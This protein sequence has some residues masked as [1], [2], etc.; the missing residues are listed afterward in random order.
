MWGSV[1]AGLGQETQKDPRFE[2]HILPIFQS[3]CLLCHGEKIQQNGLDLRTRESVLRGG[4]TGPAIVPGSVAESLLF[5]KVS[6]GEMPTGGE[7]LSAQK[8]EVIRRWIDAGGLKEGETLETARKQPKANQVTER[9]VMVTILH[10]KCLVCH[11]KRKQEGELNLRTRAG[12]LKGG[13]SGPAMVLGKPEESL[14]IKRIAAGDHPSQVLQTDYNVRPVTADQLEKLRQWVAAGAPAGPEEVLEVG[15]GPDPLVR[16]EDRKFWS[17]Q[18]PQ[19]PRVPKL[20]QK[21][22]VHT[23]IDAF[24]LEKLEAKGLSFSPQANRLTLMRRA[25]LDL[26]G[27]PPEPEEVK[28]H[29][30]D[31]SPDA[32]ERLIDRLLASPHYGERWGRHWLDAAGYADSESELG[33]DPVRPHAYRYRDY[34]IRSLNAD[35]PYDQFL[36]EQI[37]G[38]ELFDY[39]ATQELTPEQ[40]DYLVGHRIPPDDARRYLFT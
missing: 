39:K 12:L 33:G 24:L 15:S 2:S 18:P 3:N 38:D 17:F 13:K 21:H 6:S 30:E 23:P 20:R 9:E 37:A 28:T 26:I 19:R 7:K 1:S 36:L 8:I 34:V 29:L 10:L 16:D 22:L 31:R 5:E 27:L 14:L 4:E 25:Y 40:L 35:K 11:G 32:Y